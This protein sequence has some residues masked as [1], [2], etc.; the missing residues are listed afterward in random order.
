MYFSGNV[1]SNADE[2]CESG[3]RIR[4]PKIC[5][6]NP[7]NSNFNGI[8]QVDHLETWKLKI[9]QTLASVIFDRNTRCA[10]AKLC[11]V[12]EYTAQAFV[13]QH[14]ISCFWDL[15]PLR[16]RN[17]IN[18]T[19]LTADLLKTALYYVTSLKGSQLPG[20]HAPTNWSKLRKDPFSIF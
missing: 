1:S 2:N 18:G 8:L 14:Q 12:D 3:L 10:E 20:T 7:A 6:G 13:K 4:G 9:R 5:T 11:K 17:Q 15:A 19:Q 16:L